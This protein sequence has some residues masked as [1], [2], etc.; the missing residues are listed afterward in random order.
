MNIP[1]GQHYLDSKDIDEVVRVLQSGT[2]TQGSEISYFEESFASYVGSKYAVAL[3]SGTAG[4]CLA[5]RALGLGEQD[6]ILTTPISFVATANSARYVG[7]DVLFCDIDS[8]TINISLPEVEKNLEINKQNIKVILPVH[9]A[10]LPVDMESLSSLAA[11]YDG[12]N[13]VED[14]CHALGA[15]YATGERVGSCTYSAMTVFSLHPVKAIAAGEGGVV[16]TNDENLY[17]KLIR[18]RS[19]GINKLNDSFINAAQAVTGN[20][21]NPWYYEMQ[22]LGFNYRLTDF[23]AA[24][25]R[26]QLNK[27]DKFL[28]RRKQIT[29]KYDRVFFQNPM[30]RPVQKN[31]A[32]SAN[33]LY[34]V[35]IDFARIKGG[36]A[37]LMRKLIARGIYTQ[38]HYLP[39]YKHPYYSS[40]KKYEHKNYVCS[41]LYYKHCLSLP[42]YYALSD[43]E[44]DYVIEHLIKFTEESL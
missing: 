24:L 22:D 4:L 19:H 35:S 29:E 16:T 26:S 33:H 1:Y 40:M 10:G 9:F 7:A 11:A 34:V 21:I 23:Q 32:L 37:E 36:R 31:R 25:A 13:I 30:I 17:R 2:L 39:I 44:Q 38:V 18:L 8:N 20:L 15:R 5:M 42:I 3:S 6:M 28:S 41:E 27:I 12:I 43:D 14:A